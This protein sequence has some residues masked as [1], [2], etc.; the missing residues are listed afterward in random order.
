MIVEEMPLPDPKGENF[1]S[2]L[3][4]ARNN[5]QRELLRLQKLIGQ[6][7][8]AQP[9]DQELQRY[10][11][12]G[13]LLGVS[14]SLWRAV[15]QASKE[16]NK[17]DKTLEA[18]RTFLNDIIRDNAAVYRTELNAWS[19]GYYLNNARFRLVATWDESP[20]LH[21]NSHLKTTISIMSRGIGAPDRSGG[22]DEWTECFE[23]LHSMANHYEELWTANET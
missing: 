19:L 10:R 20:E 3:V 21:S 16:L 13:W 2:W 11:K 7:K 15:F 17:E 9:T 12:L 14:F 22:P 23:A 6:P 5:I 4:P 8:P 18:G 1:T